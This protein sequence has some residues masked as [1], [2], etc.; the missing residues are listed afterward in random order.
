VTTDPKEEK[1]KL[2]CSTPAKARVE[3]WRAMIAEAKVKSAKAK[4]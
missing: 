3:K 4:E 2:R 1:S